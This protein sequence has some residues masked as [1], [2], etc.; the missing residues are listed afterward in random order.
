M[1]TGSKSKKWVTG[2]MAFKKRE[3]RII[4]NGREPNW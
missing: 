1:Y 2:N 3:N 4:R